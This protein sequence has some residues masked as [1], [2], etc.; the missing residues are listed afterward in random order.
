MT[1]V[2][3]P[4][5]LS[6]E[7]MDQLKRVVEGSESK[8]ESSSVFLSLFGKSYRDDPTCLIQLALAILLDK[9]LAFIVMDDVKIPKTLKKIAFCIERVKGADPEALA[10]AVKRILNEVERGAE[11]HL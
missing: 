8:M 10:A 2:L 5:G 6:K 1:K 4:D 3:R 7:D 11:E 9:P